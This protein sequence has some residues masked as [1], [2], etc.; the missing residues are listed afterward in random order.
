VLSVLF[1][2]SES[3]RLGRLIAAGA[4]E[5]SLEELN[6]AKR[7]AEKHQPAGYGAHQSLVADLY[8]GN[9][10]LHVLQR[11]KARFPKRSDA[12]KPFTL[13]RLKHVCASDAGVYRLQPQRVLVRKDGGAVDQRAADALALIVRQTGIAAKAPEIERRAIGAQTLFP[14]LRWVRGAN[15][16][17][18]RMA[19]D[20]FWARDVAVIAHHSDPS[21]MSLAVI[22]LARASRGGVSSDEGWWTLWVRDATEDDDG[23]VT[24]TPWRVHLLSSSGNYQLPPDDPCTLWVDSSGAALPLPFT[25]VQVGLAAGSVYVEP[26]RD[27]PRFLLDLNVDDASARCVSDFQTFTP[28]VYKGSRN[29]SS[30]EMGPHAFFDIGDDEDMTTLALDPKVDVMRGLTSDFER[31]LANTRGNNPNA[32]VGETGAP[33]SGVARLIAQAPHEAV[34]DELSLIFQGWE[35]EQLWPTAMRLWDA[36]SGDPVFGEAYDVV[37]TMRRAPPIEEPETKLRRLQGEVDA[38]IISPAQ[39]AVD[40]GRYATVDAAVD[41]GISGDLK[42]SPVMPP[43][44]AAVGRAP[45]VVEDDTEDDTQEPAT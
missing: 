2:D 40:L 10:E 44:L 29:K 30:F 20:P 41:A 28:I 12:I 32:Y 3:E 36:F 16:R 37:V 31:K 13:N 4:R 6:Y 24:F 18:G 35:Q 14:R 19:L 21:D 42:R 11:I 26:D 25:V 39:M 5:W 15:G 1:E 34:I 45:L 22:V 8:S 43:A 38:G 27:L 7:L 23:A 9:S 33:P 17:P